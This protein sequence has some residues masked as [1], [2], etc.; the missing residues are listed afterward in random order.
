MV[1]EKGLVKT[2]FKHFLEMKDKRY[3]MR[4]KNRLEIHLGAK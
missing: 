1:T 2:R 4:H 3:H